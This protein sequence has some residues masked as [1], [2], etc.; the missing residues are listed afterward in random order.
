MSA[1]DRQFTKHLSK[2]CSVEAFL[3]GGFIHGFKIHQLNEG[4]FLLN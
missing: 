2:R 1:G 3:A 4:D